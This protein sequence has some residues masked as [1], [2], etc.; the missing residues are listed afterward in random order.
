MQLKTGTHFKTEKE[1]GECVR[2]GR[3][4]QRQL[5]LWYLRGGGGGRGER[6]VATL[7]QDMKG[8]TQK[9]NFLEIC[10]SVFLVFGT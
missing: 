8:H 5:W 3:V 1:L 9:D 7:S 4:P 10:C 6:V 2:L